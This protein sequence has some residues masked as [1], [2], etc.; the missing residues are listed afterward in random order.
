LT[1]Y[2]Y[3]AILGNLFIFYT[4]ILFCLY[5]IFVFKNENYD[6][7]FNIKQFNFLTIVFSLIFIILTKIVARSDGYVYSIQNKNPLVMYINKLILNAKVLLFIFSFLVSL[8]IFSS[9]TSF[10]KLILITI[11]ICIYLFMI[12]S[13]IRKILKNNFSKNN[14][15]K[16]IGLKIKKYLMNLKINKTQINYM[17]E[18][19]YIITA[20]L[21]VLALVTI[22]SLEYL[23]IEL[24]VFF[25]PLI[26][27]TLL[28]IKLI[29]NIIH[30]YFINKKRVGF[31]EFFKLKFKKKYD[32]VS[33]IIFMEFFAADRSKI[34]SENTIILKKIYELSNSNISFD[35]SELIDIILKDEDRVYIYKDSNNSSQNLSLKFSS[36]YSIFLNKVLNNQDS[37]R[38]PKE[39]KGILN[40]F[41][42]NH[43]VFKEEMM[44]GRKENVIHRNLNNLLIGLSLLL[45]T[46]LFLFYIDV[47]YS[48]YFIYFLHLIILGTLIRLILRSSEICRAFYVDMK[49]EKYNSLLTGGERISLAIKSLVEI[50][51]LCSIIYLTNSYINCLSMKINISDFINSISYSLAVSLFNVS[52][53]SNFAE[54]SSK[55]IITIFTHVIQLI[56][57]VIL[58]TLSVANYINFPKIPFYYH[59]IV[60]ESNLIVKKTS[61]NKVIEKVI[62][63]IPLNDELSKYVDEVNRKMKEREISE[64]EAYFSIITLKEYFDFD[65]EMILFKK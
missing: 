52:F 3:T 25:T 19:L 6:L 24:I 40:F 50:V 32:L 49:S 65:S 5:I 28:F 31:K 54:L 8:T 12:F 62:I 15:I 38:L 20:S 1:R 10:V 63:E 47:N 13:P 21:Y 17:I 23:I 64:E 4:W 61:F 34:N 18:F 11:T 43:K 33:K 42:K 7:V 14:D 57:S 46:Y 29:I 53:A 56:S 60:K 27:F 37:H 44:T 35:K 39:E 22:T 26:L 36:D 45:I 2:N 55:D 30:K 9:I 51:S 59:V 48:D 16:S 41:A 58:I